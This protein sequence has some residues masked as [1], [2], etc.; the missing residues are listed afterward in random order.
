MQV[1]PW[2]NAAKIRSSLQTVAGWSWLAARHPGSHPHFLSSWGQNEVEKLTDHAGVIKDKNL[3]HHMAL[4]GCRA[5]HAWVPGAP[6]LSGSSQGSVPF[7][8][9]S[10]GSV[11]PLS[12]TF[13]QRCCLSPA[14]SGCTAGSASPHRA[15]EPACVR[16]VQ[17]PD[18]KPWEKTPLHGEK[19]CSSPYLWEL[20][21]KTLTHLSF[22]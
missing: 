1:I 12:G 6:S 8:P 21:S 4:M 10:L 5:V 22:A 19:Y 7:V 18:N 20:N 16:W 14:L 13:P 2:R 9:P 11:L 3:L 17:T 15:P